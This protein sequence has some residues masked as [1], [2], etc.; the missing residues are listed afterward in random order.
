MCL[1]NIF[2]SINQTRKV[3]FFLRMEKFKVW[4]VCECDV[5][6][7][8]FQLSK[9]K[10]WNPHIHSYAKPISRF[11]FHWL[12]FF[13]K[14]PPW[15]LHSV[16]LGSPWNPLHLHYSTSSPLISHM[17]P[18]LRTITLIA[19]PFAC[20]SKRLNFYLVSAG[21]PF[22]LEVFSLFL[23]VDTRHSV[24]DWIFVDDLTPD[25]LSKIVIL[26]TSEN[27][28]FVFFWGFWIFPVFAV[29]FVLY[30]DFCCFGAHLFAE[31]PV[32]FHHGL[33]S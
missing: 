6:T 18:P 27:P 29:V 12:H 13:F 17:E 19:L 23:E 25:I 11:S 9:A 7:S 30:H 32:S 31:W 5:D 15:H 20:S 10:P 33:C 1:K 22:P 21:F 14:P 4:T 8:I 28:T 24:Q 2:S 16:W 26:C 3:V